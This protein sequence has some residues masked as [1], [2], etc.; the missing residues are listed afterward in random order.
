M[1]YGNLGRVDDA[2]ANALKAY[3]LRDRVSEWERLFI[4]AQY[5]DRVTG[6]LDKVLATGEMWIQTYPHDRTARNRLAAAYN[7]L[8]QPARALA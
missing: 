5:H 6:E 1:V 8:G 3:E 2:R 7:Q 4:T